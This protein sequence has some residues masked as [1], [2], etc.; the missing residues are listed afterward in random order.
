MRWEK[1]KSKRKQ[2]QEQEQKVW[3]REAEGEQEEEEGEEKRSKRGRRVSSLYL[4]I[5]LRRSSTFSC[6]H[7]NRGVKK[8]YSQPR[9]TKQTRVKELNSRE[10]KREGRG[11][12]LYLLSLLSSLTLHFP[13]SPS[14]STI[15]FFIPLPHPQRAAEENRDSIFSLSRTTVFESLPERI[16]NRGLIGKTKDEAQTRRQVHATEESANV[17]SALKG[18]L[19]L[20]AVLLFSLPLIFPSLLFFLF[21]FSSVFSSH[22]LI[23]S[24]ALRDEMGA[25][26]SLFYSFLSSL[27]FS[28]LLLFSS[29]LLFSSLTS[30]VMFASSWSIDSIAAATAAGYWSLRRLRIA[31]LRKLL[32]VLRRTEENS[33]ELPSKLLPLVRIVVK[34]NT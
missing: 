27:L 12:L 8:R 34:H 15:L 29:P 25:P 14:L 5:V 26:P 17:Q 30:E 32:W 31:I 23:P 9:P 3:A 13:P 33:N 28:S 21:L 7:R 20:F 22:L 11:W 16:R 1:R 19:S 10:R 4:S 2:E 24:I 6:F 18:M